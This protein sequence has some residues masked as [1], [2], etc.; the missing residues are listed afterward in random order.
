[1]LTRARVFVVTLV[2]AAAGFAACAQPPDA[3][4]APVPSATVVPADLPILLPQETRLSN[5]KQ[6]TRRPRPFL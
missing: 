4:K 5:V 1:M 6:L 3:S 2:L